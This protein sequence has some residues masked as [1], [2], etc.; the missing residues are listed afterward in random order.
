MPSS[1]MGHATVRDW[2]A[3]NQGRLA[4]AGGIEC[5]I[6]AM[7]HYK[8]HSALNLQACGVLRNLASTPGT[9]NSI[10]ACGCGRRHAG[11]RGAGDCVGER[12][13]WRTD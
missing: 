7:D 4:A 3:H 9:Q 1:L 13:R 11:E 5:V 8:A 12:A 6:G 10:A 2:A